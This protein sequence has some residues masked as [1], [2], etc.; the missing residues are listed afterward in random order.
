MR[1]WMRAIAIVFL[2]GCVNPQAFQPPPENQERWHK[3]GATNTEIVIALLEC[4]DTSPRAPFRDAPDMTLNEV[5]LM[6]IC[7]EANGF[8]S[9]LYGSSQSYCKR[10]NSP[11][12]ACQLG[13]P[14][15][16]RDVNKRLN[17]VFCRTYVRAD[18]CIP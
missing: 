17:S 6:K 7:M 11:P 15:P 5:V 8:T 1:E 14:A 4:G 18:V 12:P 3:T 10:L 2:S 13:T 9:D 16:L